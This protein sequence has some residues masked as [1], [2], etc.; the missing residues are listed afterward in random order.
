[1]TVAQDGEPPK[2]R[3]GQVGPKYG[4]AAEVP[5]TIAAPIA[6]M[7][8]PSITQEKTRDMEYDVKAGISGLQPLP[9]GVHRTLT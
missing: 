2:V 5:S 8:A 6:T 4:T 3:N 7:L 1:M 9:R